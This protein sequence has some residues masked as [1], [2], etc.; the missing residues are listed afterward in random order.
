MSG[1]MSVV[2]R[3]HSRW[4]GP[5]LWWRVVHLSKVALGLPRRSDGLPWSQDWHAAISLPLLS[6][7]CQTLSKSA[8]IILAAGGN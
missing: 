6:P 8:S 7:R 4:I 2:S 3:D 5:F 1:A